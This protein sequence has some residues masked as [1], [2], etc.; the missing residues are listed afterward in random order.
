MIIGLTGTN[1]SGKTVAAEHLRR[2][3]FAFYSLSDVIREELARSGSEANRENLIAAGNRL[4]A[5]V[6]PRRFWRRRVA[7]KFRPDRNYVVDSIRSPYEVQAL[8]EEGDFYLLHLDAPPAVRYERVRMRGG[9]RTPTSFDEFVRQE[10]RE[11]ASP[12]SSSQQ[13]ARHLGRSDETIRND[14]SLEDFTARVTE[15]AKG[16]MMGTPR[17]DWDEYFMHIAL[18]VAMRSNCMKRKVAAVIVKDLRIISTG[19]NG[20]PRGV[21]NCNEGGCPRCNSL[22]DTGANLEDCLCSHAEENAIVQA[23][24]HGIRVN[25]ATLYSTCSPCLICT[26]DDHQRGNREGGLQLGLPP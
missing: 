25:G 11:L 24:Y 13:T 8:R 1:G 16:W 18:I 23:A 14:G 7:R 3:G 19:Y 9:E 4:R 10:E 20:T 5:D 12:D 6:R 26:K 2:K 17:P 15:V 22:A 21:T